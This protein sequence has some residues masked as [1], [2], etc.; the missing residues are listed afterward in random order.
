MRPFLSAA[1]AVAL[2]AC[3]SGPAASQMITNVQQ[4]SEPKGTVEGRITDAATG[5]GVPGATVTVYAGMPVTAMSDMTGRYS[6][7]PLAAGSSYDVYFE[8]P[9]YVRRILSADLTGAAGNYPVGNAVA[10]VDV[11]MSKGDATLS[12][13]VLTSTGKVAAGAQVFADLRGLGYDLLLSSKTDASGK[14]T[15][16]NVP[17]TASGLNITVNVAPFD[18]N[19]DGMPDYTASS[20]SFRMYPGFTTTGTITLSSVGVTLTQSN[21]SD[22][23][24]APTDPITLTFAS[25]IAV[26]QSTITLRSNQTGLNIGAT[27]TWDSTTTQLTFTPVGTLIIGQS[28]TLSYT[29]RSTSGAQSSNSIGFTVRPSSTATPPGAV[30]NLHV[31]SPGMMKYD[32]STSNVTLAWDP[33]MDAG[34]YRIYAKDTLQNPAYLA[35]TTINNGTTTTQSVNLSAYFGQP[36][37]PL[38][39]SNHITIA[40]V[41]LDKAGNEAPLT[42]ASTVDLTDNTIPVLSFASEGGFANNAGSAT[43][44][45][46]TYSLNFTEPMLPSVTPQ[47]ALGNAAVT[48]TF[49]WQSTTVGVF[50]LTVPPMTDGTGPTMVSGA[51][52]T[53]GN[54]IM[55][56]N[57]NLL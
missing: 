27:Q 10:T 7:G 41:A 51:K 32:Y 18:E 21:I 13:L 25:T 15:L 50:T 26:N 19:M 35:L 36:G 3:G 16:M 14:V 48:A 33:L 12:V 5:A 22:G 38:G 9:G 46:I 28:Y 44:K 11:D 20:T 34:G 57:G 30:A 54:V 17:G 4:N 6:L 31:T 52:D 43:A 37:A 53:S 24:L 1:C 8:A 47:L 29:V 42:M 56:F 23:D 2:A 55:T 45:M 39:F 49:A 40:V